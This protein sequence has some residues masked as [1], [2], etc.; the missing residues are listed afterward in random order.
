MPRQMPTSGLEDAATC[1]SAAHHSKVPQVRHGIGKRADAG[2]D[3][4]VRVDD[5]CGR[6][7]DRHLQARLLARLLHTE[8]I[9]H[10]EIDDGDNGNG[11]FRHSP[12][13]L[14]DTR[15]LAGSAIS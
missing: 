5:L 15:C 4:G 2:K 3:H 14:R 12:A 1:C 7:G 8:Q 9:A 6:L 10:A 11:A 13:L